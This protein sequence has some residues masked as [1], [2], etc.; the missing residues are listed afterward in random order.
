MESQELDLYRRTTEVY[1]KQGIKKITMDDMAQ[2]LKVSKK[3]LYKFVKN[4]PELVSKS[5]KWKLDF[6]A[7]VLT[8]IRERNL[9]AIEELWEISS[10]HIGHL[11]M[12]HPSLHSDLAKY[13]KEAWLMFNEFHKTGF[14]YQIT[15]NNIKK[16]IAQGLYRN[17][18]DVEVVAKLYLNKVDMV[19]DPSIF[20]PAQYNFGSVCR[21]MVKYHANGMATEKG[22]LEI[23]EFWNDNKSEPGFSKANHQI[24]ANL[25][26][27]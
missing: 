15:I 21:E 16:G 14:L 13:Y 11:K 20:V 23:A 26:S 22:R 25:L 10:Y 27:I 24:V 17:D 3:T 18:F 1:M 19:F 7:Q 5:M 9:G 4:R 6:D 2:E 12:M 8:A